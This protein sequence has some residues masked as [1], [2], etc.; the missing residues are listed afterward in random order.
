M[1]DED[2]LDEDSEVPIV[3]EPE[4]P[5]HEAVIESMVSSKFDSPDIRP[6]M[7][8]AKIF[9]SMLSEASKLSKK[10][11]EIDM[12]KLQKQE[13]FLELA[14]KNGF[15]N[16]DIIDHLKEALRMA[17]VRQDTR[18]MTRL[19]ELL[20]KIFLQPANDLNRA[21]F[22]LQQNNIKMSGTKSGSGTNID[23]LLSSIPRH[24]VK[25]W[26]SDNLQDM[27]DGK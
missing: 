24:E 18:A 12:A 2:I 22:Q 7:Q 10:S 11:A 20:D 19:V 13:A 16:N 9:E 26:I 25:K 4:E 1:S 15:S 5:E 17:K 23:E 8:S 21:F 27:I 3:E 6:A 14:E